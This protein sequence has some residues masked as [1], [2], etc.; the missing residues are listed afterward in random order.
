M[1]PILC[2]VTILLINTVQAQFNSDA[3]IFPDD[4]N[5]LGSSCIRE[6]DGRLGICTKMPDCRGAEVM[7]IDFCKAHEQ[8]VCCLLET[9]YTS[10]DNRFAD[11]GVPQKPEVLHQDVPQ[12]RDNHASQALIGELYEDERRIKWRCGGSLI[13]PRYVITSAHCIFSVNIP[14][15][16][17]ITGNDKEQ[18]AIRQTDALVDDVYI[19][20][21]YDPYKLYHD[22][23]IVRLSKA[24]W[25]FH[26]VYL[27]TTNSNF[28]R[29]PLHISGWMNTPEN[30]E[31]FNFVSDSVQA[32][33]KDVCSKYFQIPELANG[34]IE[35]Q[36]CGML[37]PNSSLVPCSGAF[38][39]PLETQSHAI[40]GIPSFTYGCDNDRPFVFT[41]IA[42]FSPWIRT[43]IA[44]P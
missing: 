33:P 25:D 12:S 40:V 4:D 17:R 28:M 41:N 7:L 30:L 42:S 15:Y 5:E 18:Q 8:T 11:D 37:A 14:T 29:E 13:A 43:V 19:H 3:I 26:P 36:I 23:A 35:N 38:L 10:I 32:I 44:R 20:P 16:I 22:I 31:E 1:A 27:P 21:D 6:T 39:G 34:I 9:L 24:I 2:I